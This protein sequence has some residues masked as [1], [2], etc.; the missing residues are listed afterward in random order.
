MVVLL[1]YLLRKADLVTSRRVILWGMKMVIGRIKIWFL[2]RGEVLCGFCGRE[3]MRRVVDLQNKRDIDFGYSG[4]FHTSRS[5]KAIRQY[6]K[7]HHP[8]SLTVTDDGFTTYWLFW[9]LFLTIRTPS[10]HKNNSW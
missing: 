6:A 8:F 2:K 1:A 10:Y 4:Y 5:M 7:E 9:R 3:V